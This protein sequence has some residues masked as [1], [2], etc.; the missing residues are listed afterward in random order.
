MC[1]PLLREGFGRKN[2]WIS[3]TNAYLRLGEPDR[4]TALATRQDMIARKLTALSTEN[5]LKNEPM[6]NTLPKEPTE[7]IENDDPIDPM[8]KDDL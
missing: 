6:E 2:S 5:A 4:I 7:P 8:E 3:T 1:V